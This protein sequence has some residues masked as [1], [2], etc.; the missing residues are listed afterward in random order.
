M[1]LTQIVSTTMANFMLLY[2]SHHL[3]IWAQ[4]LKADRACP[5]LALPCIISCVSSPSQG[6]WAEVCSA[7]YC[8]YNL[9]LLHINDED[10][11]QVRLSFNTPT[12]THHQQLLT[13]MPSQHN[14]SLFPGTGLVNISASI[15]S[16]RM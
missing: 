10:E 7:A 6:C 4:T 16:V 11:L 14:W 9:W 8:R 12:Q 2:L 15:A 13:P 5:D 3:A 1:L